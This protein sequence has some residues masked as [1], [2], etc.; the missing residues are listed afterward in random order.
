MSTIAVKI[1]EVLSRFPRGDN[2]LLINVLQE[3]QAVYGWISEQNVYAISKHL[4]VPSSKI[5]GVA[6]FYSQFRLRPLG[7]HIVNLCRGTACH[8]RG[9]ERLIPVFEQEMKCKLGETTKDGKFS[10]RAINCMG[11]CSLAP[12]INIDSDFYGNVKTNDIKKILRKY[13]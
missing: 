6:T 11:C 7:R 8:V 13:E 3:V 4:N 10:L 2:S 5:Y 9:S 12:A 1:D